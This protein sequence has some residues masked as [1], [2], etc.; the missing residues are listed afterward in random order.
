MEIASAQL[1]CRF[2]RFLIQ[3]QLQSAA[4]SSIK[5]NAVNR[6]QRILLTSTRTLSFRSFSIDST[7]RL[8]SETGSVGA[9]TDVR[10]LNFWVLSG[11]HWRRSSSFWCFVWS[12][13]S[14]LLTDFLKMA[15]D[16]P[17]TTALQSEEAHGPGKVPSKVASQMT[18]LRDANAKY[19]SLLKM[20][21]ERI[22]AQE[23]EM[24]ALRGMLSMV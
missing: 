18:K 2:P 1:R 7:D 15:E 6:C 19:K 17:E 3:D 9:Q 23:E 11:R 16:I 10:F 12:L 4:L 21:K 5:I 14:L 24:E 22:Q 8:E 20:A 13:G